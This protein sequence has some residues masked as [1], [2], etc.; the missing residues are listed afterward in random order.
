MRIPVKHIRLGGGGA[1]SPLWRRIQSEVYGREVEVVEAEEGA[2]YGAAI[3]AGV[4]ANLWPSVEAACASVVRVADRIRPNPDN[5]AILNEEYASYRRI[6]PAM[7]SI[8][9]S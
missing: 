6:Y 9:P 2:A 3:L 1:R 5:V 8:F 4:G 7:K